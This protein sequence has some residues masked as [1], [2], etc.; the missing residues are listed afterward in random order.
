M[1]EVEDSELR[2]LKDRLESEYIRLRCLVQPHYI[3][4]SAPAFEKAFK[5]AAVFCKAHKITPEQYAIA[6]LESLD[7]HRENFY[8]S[9]FGSTSANQVAIDYSKNFS[10]PLEELYE[11]QKEMLRHMVLEMG[12]DAVSTL[13][14]PRLRFYAW[15]R[16]L[17]TKE[18]VK[19]IIEAYSEA[20][21]K[22]MTAELLTFLK[23][24]QLDVERIQ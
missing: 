4:H 11:Y 14:N 21:R 13:L 3:Y 19:E 10:V 17:A 8:P 16:I 9:Y 24:K 20:A 12:R 22:E 23:S 7:G 5:K 1:D 15:F 2:D 6:L 18:P